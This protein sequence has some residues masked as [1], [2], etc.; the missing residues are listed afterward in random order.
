MNEITG[1]NIVQRMQTGIFQ[2][3]CLRIWGALSKSFPYIEKSRF[4]IKIRYF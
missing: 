2:E 1:D 4:N 3:I